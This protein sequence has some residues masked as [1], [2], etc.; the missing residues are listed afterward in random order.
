MQIR[1]YTAVVAAVSGCASSCLA[2]WTVTNLHP[3]GA[4][5]SWSYGVDATGQVGAARMAT[6]VRASLW[7]GSAASWIDLTPS[8]S[9]QA[10]CSSTWGGTH[11]GWFAVGGGRE[12]AA[13][14]TAGGM[15]DLNPAG[16]VDSQAQG[17]SDTQ[18]VGWAVIDGVSRASL[19][20]GSAASWIDLTPPGSSTSNVVT[21]ADGVQGGVATFNGISH[22]SIWYG[23]ASTWISLNAPGAE[24]GCVYTIFGG[25]QGGQMNVG[26]LAH[27]SVW[28][29]SPASRVDLHPAH[30]TGH[31]FVFGMHEGQQ[32]GNVDV[33]GR[34]RATLW[35]GSVGSFEDLHEFLPASFQSSTAMGIYSDG[36]TL[37]VVG[38]GFNTATNRNEALMWTRPDCGTSW[39]AAHPANISLVPATTAQFSVVAAGAEPEYAWRKNG[40]PLTNGVRHSGVDTATLTIINVNSSDEAGYDCVITTPCNTAQSGIATLNCDPILTTQPPHRVH[41]DP[42]GVQLSV[43]VPAGAA[44]SYRWRQDGQNLFNIAGV[45][46][47]VT[48]RTLTVHSDDPSLE[49]VYDVV[50][51]NAC[52][53]VVSAAA[54]VRKCFGDYDDDGDV[55]TDADIEAFFR[56][57]AGDCCAGCSADYNRDGDIGTDS[58]IE[59]F[60]SVLAG[61]PC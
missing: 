56:C 45:F 46:S 50:V 22:A 39:F 15:I 18:Q 38:H 6:A 47:G 12:H 41:L 37:R 11:A 32:V 60:F 19:W 30:A 28:S 17:I 4:L 13:L 42:G 10:Y 25:Q 48:T 34:T 61:G 1:A 26:G 23:S 35:S 29:G 2:Q 24:S 36:V 57:L 5:N 40:V 31:S 27:A 58:D 16:S 54:E 44:Y 52:G 53:Q 20:E 55:G 33:N 3:A 8:G 7:R 14:W 43:S 59:A 21:V 9:A 49:G 51:T